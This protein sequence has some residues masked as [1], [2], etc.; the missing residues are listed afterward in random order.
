MLLRQKHR[1][2]VCNQPFGWNHSVL[3]SV[4]PVRGLA[5]KSGRL[6]LLD[7]LGRLPFTNHA[8]CP[9]HQVVLSVSAWLRYE[10]FES[11]PISCDAIPSGHTLP[12]KPRTRDCKHYSDDL[13]HAANEGIVMLRPIRADNAARRWGRQ[14]RPEMARAG[15]RAQTRESSTR[16]AGPTL[17][18]RP[19]AELGTERPARTPQSALIRRSTNWSAAA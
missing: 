13:L 18:P 4:P 11:V 9:A 19:R 14:R 12:T 17:A 6:T 16:Q 1:A 5:H 15:S 2:P 10:R 3:A 7:Q 8:G